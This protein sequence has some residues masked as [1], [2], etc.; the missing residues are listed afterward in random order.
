MHVCAPPVPVEA[1]LRGKNAQVRK[2]FAAVRAA[3]KKLGPVA[4]D[5][6]KTRVA[7]AA[8]TI[9]L[10]LTPQQN[11]LRGCL[12]LARRARHPT[13]ERAISPS[14]GR[15]YHFFRLT[16]SR[17]LDR[18]L[19][20]LLAEAYRSV[21]RREKP[22]QVRRAPKELPAAFEKSSHKSRVAGHV[23]RPLWRC[24]KCGRWFVTRNLWHS[25]ARISL[26][27]HFRGKSPK[28]RSLF[29]QLVAALKKNGPLFVNANKTRISFQARMRFGGVQV[30][31]HALLG[32]LILTR[33]V[34]HPRFL[35]AISVGPRSYGHSFRLT[36]PRQLDA[37]LRR[38]LAEAYRVGQQQHL[39]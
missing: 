17:Q 39:G 14:P 23:S 10:E 27:S 30:Q 35:R 22:K 25:C 15:H 36:E 1:H 26:A 11:A 5:S 3:V 6:T 16:E 20:R 34:R 12:T 13:F 37:R 21:G 33:R 18:R 32:H 7:F 29:N 9:F 24:P 19:R 38:Y 2:L 8:Q 31:K 4:T 28:L